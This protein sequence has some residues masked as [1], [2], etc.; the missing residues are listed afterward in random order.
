MRRSKK[1]HDDAIGVEMRAAKK[2]YN[3]LNN[4]SISGPFSFP[5]SSF[6]ITTV[7]QS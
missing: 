3:S 4:I 1:Q 2:K 7:H 5:F 6:S